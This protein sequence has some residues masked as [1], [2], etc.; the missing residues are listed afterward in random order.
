MAYSYNRTAFRSAATSTLPPLVRAYATLVTLELRLKE[1]LPELGF[2]CPRNHDVPEML[3]LLS[4]TLPGAQKANLKSLSLALRS[5]ISYLWCEDVS[6]NPRHVAASVYPNM[7]YLR[8]VQDW[9]ASASSEAD[10]T[11]LVTLS[12]QIA[13]AIGRSTGVTP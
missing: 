1:V 13:H 11:A 2:N 7:R 4:T 5:T 10:L 12:S 6:G 3:R 9:P 8:H